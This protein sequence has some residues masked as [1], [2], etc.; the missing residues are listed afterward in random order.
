VPFESHATT[1]KLPERTW[2]PAFKET[3]GAEYGLTE[4]ILKEM[5]PRLFPAEVDSV[6][7]RVGDLLV[8]GVPGEMT[9]RL[10]LEIKDRARAATGAKYP[11]IGGLADV[12]VSYILPTDEYR[13]GGY[14]ASVSF[15]G[16][17]LGPTIVEGVLHGIGSRE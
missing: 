4:D 15:Y 5:L 11:V 16:E 13:K 8:L 3:G 9:A 10:G 6:S 14:E 1:I 12:W 2:H 17:T 7:L